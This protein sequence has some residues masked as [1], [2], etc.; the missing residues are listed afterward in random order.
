MG[1]DFVEERKVLADRAGGNYRNGKYYVLANGD[2]R[3]AW[4]KDDRALAS[5]VAGTWCVCVLPRALFVEEFN[6]GNG[7]KDMAKFFGLSNRKMLR[8]L[9]EMDLDIWTKIQNE[10][11]EDRNLERVAKRHGMK[12]KTLSKKLKQMGTKIRS[13]RPRREFNQSEVSEA[14]Q[15]SKSIRVFARAMGI[16]RWKA[17]KLKVEY[18]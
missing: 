1:P 5:N 4:A 14:L 18:E 17:K 6:S 10:Y 12:P 16:S 8:L 7:A 9:E 3:L 11:L 15:N 2:V 13:G